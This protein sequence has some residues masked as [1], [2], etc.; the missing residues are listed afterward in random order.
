MSHCR[1]ISEWVY[2]ED[3][4]GNV[5]KIELNFNSAGGISDMIENANVPPS[6]NVYVGFVENFGNDLL[7]QIT[8]DPNY[9][10]G[11]IIL[12]NQNEAQTPTQT[13]FDAIRNFLLTKL[14][15]NPPTS[16]QVDEAIGTSPAGRTRWDISQAL[17]AWMKSRT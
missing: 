13:E 2:S 15:E 16:A 7:T 1:L 10:S 17:I 12:T 9:G 6:P 14:T 3:L 5:S 4:E 8:S 11:A